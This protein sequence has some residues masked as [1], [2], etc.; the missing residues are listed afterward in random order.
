ALYESF[1]LDI[2]DGRQI[3][4]VGFPR[5]EARTSFGE[6]IQLEI[7]MG[8]TTRT[9]ATVDSEFAKNYAAAPQ[10]VFTRKIF[11]LPDLGIVS[12]PP[13]TD[14]VWVPLDTPFTHDAAQN[15][16]VEYRVYA[17]SKSNQA[18]SYFL[19]FA[20]F[21]SPITA[22]GQACPTSSGLLPKLESQRTAIGGTW[23]VALTNATASSSGTLFIGLGLLPTPLPI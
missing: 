3:T 21:H 10:V 4:H 18:F 17:N 19:D 20:Q 9:V 7:L 13:V 5:D 15:L 1:D 14:T 23:R 6:Q 16:I 2:P 12:N 8:R 22:H 11:A